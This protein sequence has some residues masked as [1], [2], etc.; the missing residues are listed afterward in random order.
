[1]CLGTVVGNYARIPSANKFFV[2]SG[3]CAICLPFAEFRP[4]SR[5]SRWR[6]E[7][8]HLAFGPWVAFEMC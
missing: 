7:R 2:K 1:M 6:G 8:M 5:A 3:I 4:R